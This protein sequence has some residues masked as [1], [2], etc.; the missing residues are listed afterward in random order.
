MGAEPGGPKSGA[1]GEGPSAGAPAGSPRRGAA[2]PWAAARRARSPAPPRRCSGGWEAGR[3]RL[4]K[5]GGGRTTEVRSVFDGSFEIALGRSKL[6]PYD[7]RVTQR[8]SF[9]SRKAWGRPDRGAVLLPHLLFYP[10]LSHPDFFSLMKQSAIFEGLGVGF[11]QSSQNQPKFIK[12]TW[13]FVSLV[14][15]GSFLLIGALGEEYRC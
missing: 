7:C 10:P 3:L 5:E 11:R 13:Y 12:I 15:R 8:A 2:P 1:C 6:S 9:N 14:H 4:G